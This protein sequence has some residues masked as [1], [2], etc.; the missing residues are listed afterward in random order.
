MSKEEAKKRASISQSMRV[1]ASK[2]MDFDL[3]MV[4]KHGDYEKNAEENPR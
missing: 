3:R 4:M 1:N 2:K